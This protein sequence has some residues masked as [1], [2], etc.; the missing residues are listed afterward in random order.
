MEELFEYFVGLLSILDEIKNHVV[1]EDF[2]AESLEAKIRIIEANRRNALICIRLY[3]I[4]QTTKDK[5]RRSALLKRFYDTSARFA[6]A[7]QTALA[8]DVDDDGDD[9]EMEQQ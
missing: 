2:D 8:L 7:S 5:K 1:N 9:D 4:I 6:E 3:N